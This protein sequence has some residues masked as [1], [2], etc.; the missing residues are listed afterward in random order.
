VCKTAILFG[1]ELAKYG[2]GSSHPFNNNRIYAFWNKLNSRLSDKTNIEVERPVVADEETILSFHEESYVSRVKQ[3]STI[4]SGYLD[5]GDTPALKGIFEAAS[6]VVGSS[7]EAL[8]VAVEKKGGI[9]HAFNPIGGLHH[10]YRGNASGF[11]V[12]NDIGI[13]ILRARKK[14]KLARILYVDIDAHHGD[15]VYYEFEDDPLVFIADIHEDGKYLFPGTGSRGET[16]K[17]EAE[18]TKLNLPMPPGSTDKEFIESFGMVEKFINEVARPDLIIL[19]CGA[20]CVKLDPLTHLQY[21]PYAH[22]YASGSLHKLA[23]KYSGGRIV[24]LGGG[25]YNLENIGDAWTNVVLS[26][27]SDAYNEEDNA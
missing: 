6:V 16:G 1:D 2:F 19:Q 3:L 11:C 9:E 25:G 10:A 15:G 4:G 24:A 13:M 5:S 20:D 14:Y 26:F 8:E 21:S 22:K 12:F 18:G 7:L 23:H 27:V 17:G